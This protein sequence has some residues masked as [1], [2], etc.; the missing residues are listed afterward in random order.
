MGE[1]T[2]QNDAEGSD[3][4]TIRALVKRVVFH[5]A[6]SG[7]GVYRIELEPDDEETALVG[8]SGE[9]AQGASIE[10]TGRWVL[11]PSYGKQ[12]AF[13]TVRNCP[14][15]TSQAVLRR[16]VH[17]PGLKETLARRLVEVFGVDTLRLLS[18]EP[19]R[20]L[21]VE[22]IGPK[23]LA[24]LVEHHRTQVG[25]LAELEGRL[26]E[27]ELPIGWANLLNAKY[28]DR[29]LAMLHYEPFRLAREVPGIG[30]LSADRIA[31][32]MG[33]DLLAPARLDAG[34]DHTLARALLDGHCALPLTRLIAK[35]QT[36]LQVEQALVHAAAARMIEHG[37]LLVDVVNDEELVFR[38]QEWDAQACVVSAIAE[39]AILPRS[40][41]QVGELPAHLSEGQ[42]EAVFAVARHGVTLLTGGP[43]TGKTTVVRQVIE[44][45][46]ANGE[47]VYLAAPTGRAAK[48]L[49]E[50]TGV[51][52][53]TIHRLLEI[54]GETGEFTYN[55]QQPLPAGLVVIDEASMLDV[56]LAAALCSALT[57]EH[58]L[59][60]VG[61]PDQLPSVGPGNVLH[62]ILRACSG[63]QQ[64]VPVVRLE[65]IFRQ[66][67]GSS[68]VVNAHRV[69]HGQS[70]IS[71][72][73]GAGAAFFVV[74]SSDPDRVHDLV[75][76]TVIERIP[77]VYNLDAARHVQVLAPMHR[78][79]AG[80]AALNR[81]LQVAHGRDLDGAAIEL[82][83]G[84][85]DERRFCVDD[86]VMQTRNDY[87]RNVF[88]GDIGWV[89]E[90]EPYQRRLVADFDGHRVVYEGANLGDLQL[91]YAMSIHKS[92]G[93]EYP[94]VVVPLVA[95]HSVMLRRNLLY[96]AMTRAVSLCVIIGD[97]RSVE[98]A[99][100]RAD[101]LTR[102]TTLEAHLRRALE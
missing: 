85:P 80:V 42:V 15:D 19:Q 29:A 38:P 8:R 76:R 56:S 95:E 88:N 26:A 59:L 30:F 18:E 9:L 93:S 32:V 5:A 52:A 73:V 21:E 100:A 74:R 58:R 41:L 23:T 97:P 4:A 96:T 60:L 92:Q 57:T 37:E 47:E 84:T 50:S 17:Y 33:A 66:A 102:Y 98:K 75:L 68:I 94:A 62:D 81:S 61:D 3:L 44:M 83:V 22:G 28:G 25:P 1:G 79:R 53:K 24:R 87:D 20:L 55:A 89:V 34:L 45:A 91:A 54:Q 48:R 11:H 40:P 27:L 77:A 65:Q 13:V 51:E 99:I 69:L 2:P 86:R 10:A 78:G 35:T 16:L 36:L 31:K 70:V 12:F 14:A 39:L 64:T 71:D 7:Y 49:S 90:L 6:Q 67:H 101:A 72:E 46:L 43:G 63:T 82:A